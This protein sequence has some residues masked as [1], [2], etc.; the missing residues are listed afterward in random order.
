MSEFIDLWP[1]EFYLWMSWRWWDGCPRLQILLR[2]CFSSEN[3]L[4]TLEHYKYPFLSLSVSVSFYSGSVISSD[5]SY[6]EGIVELFIVNINCSASVDS[7]AGEYSCVSGYVSHSTGEFFFLLR[8]PLNLN[9]V[10]YYQCQRR[11]KVFSL[12]I[13]KTFKRF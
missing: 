7:S 11:K 9:G 3:L 2:G 12:Y 4:D 8:V 6:W 10:W 1:P 5:K 13:P